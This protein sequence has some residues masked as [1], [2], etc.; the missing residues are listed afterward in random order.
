MSRPPPGIKTWLK[1]MEE[2]PEIRKIALELLAN[3]QEMMER[4]ST[5]F[6]FDQFW[7]EPTNPRMRRFP[8]H[9][10]HRIKESLRL[11]DEIKENRTTLIASI[12]AHLLSRARMSDELKFQYIPAFVKFVDEEVLDDKFHES[13]SEL[14][15]QLFILVENQDWDAMRKFRTVLTDYHV[16]MHFY[17]FDLEKICR[18]CGFCKQLDE[19][20]EE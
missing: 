8:R 14:E 2:V 3:L 18:E 20:D 7:R 15:D 12:D 13:C 6:D 16:N 19:S 1:A 4:V 11:F 10:M 17:T 9:I 5:G